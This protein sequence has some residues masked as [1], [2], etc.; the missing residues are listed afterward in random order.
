VK[1]FFV[2]IDV[3]ASAV[4]WNIHYFS[5]GFPNIRIINILQW[6]ALLTFI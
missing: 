4:E 5:R 1:V 6:L 2:Q 3:F